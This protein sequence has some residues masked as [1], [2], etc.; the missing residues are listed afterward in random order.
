MSH[1]IRIEIITLADALRVLRARAEQDGATTRADR[2]TAY[3]VSSSSLGE[4]ERG[5]RLATDDEAAALAAYVESA[6]ILIRN[7]DGEQPIGSLPLTP[8]AE[9][10]G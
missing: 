4:L 10:G 6:G 7:A 8:P 5:E 1:L 9:E 3:G 2:A